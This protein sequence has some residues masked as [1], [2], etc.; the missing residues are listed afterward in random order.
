MPS[1]LD[2]NTQGARAGLTARGADST[3]GR[4][5]YMW[6]CWDDKKTPPRQKIL[7]LDDNRRK[8]HRNPRA[9]PQPLLCRQCFRGQQYLE[10]GLFTL[11]GLLQLQPHVLFDVL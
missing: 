3:V 10:V 5:W 6:L 4:Q 1:I 11:S 7:S 9:N 2:E 8:R